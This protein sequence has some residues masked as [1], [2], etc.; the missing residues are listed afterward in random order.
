MGCT[1]YIREQH[2]CE[3][4]LQLEPLLECTLLLDQG[5]SHRWGLDVSAGSHQYLPAATYIQG[6][7]SH[8]LAVA[9]CQACHDAMWQGTAGKP[10]SQM[11]TLLVTVHTRSGQIGLIC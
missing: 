7:P 5:N 2:T 6:R 1:A 9:T 8:E 4:L 3:L 11:P 10:L